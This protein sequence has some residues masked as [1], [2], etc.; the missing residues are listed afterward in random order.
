MAVL[1]NYKICDNAKECDAIAA[2]P[3]GAFCWDEEK[4]TIHVKEDLCINC[5]K[6]ECCTVGA[7]KVTNSDDEYETVKK[8]IEEDSRNINDLF[9]DRY[10]AAPIQS[11]FLINENEIEELIL[12]SK[13]PL[14]IELFD[15]DATECLLKSIPVKE[16]LL[17]FNKDAVFR[18]INIESEKLLKIYKIK[19]LPALLFIK[20]NKVVNVIEGY[21]LESE[22][23]ELFNKIKS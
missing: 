18:K 22:K 5:G 17:E 9:I 11:E 2:C 15:L 7:V 8:E 4:Q 20:N 19:E 12:N 3:T 10:G 14:I 1:I 21:Y 6:C 23:Q 13:R 16:I